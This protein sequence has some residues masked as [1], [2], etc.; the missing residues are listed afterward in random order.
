MQN[1]AMQKWAAQLRSC[2]HWTQEQAR[3]VL[4]RQRAS[5]E[6]VTEFAHRMGFVPQRLFWW[7][8]QLGDSEPA[9]ASCERAFVPVVVRDQHPACATRIVV[10][11]GDGIQVQVNEVDASTAG[12]VALLLSARG[13]S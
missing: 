13:R 6:G 1:R 7:R 11:L 10:D 2:R 12:W 8:G 5:G 3:E 4:Q 9:E